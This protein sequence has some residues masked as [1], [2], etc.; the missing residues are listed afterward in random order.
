MS[1]LPM[2]ARGAAFTLRDTRH[3]KRK[4]HVSGLVAQ[5]TDKALSGAYRALLT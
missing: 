5:L 2:K 1:Y 3:F 4:D